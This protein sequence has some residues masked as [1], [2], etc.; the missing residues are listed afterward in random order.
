MLFAK[1]EVSQINLSSCRLFLKYEARYDSGSSRLGIAFGLHHFRSARAVYWHG[2]AY[3]W[4]I[5]A[6]GDMDGVGGNQA[7]RV[8]RAGAA[9]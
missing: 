9:N 3:R 2:H 6:G 7:R 5:A 4:A 1:N 8:Q